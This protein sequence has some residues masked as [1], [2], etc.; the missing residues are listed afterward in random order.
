MLRL[1]RSNL[2]WSVPV[3][4]IAS[5]VGFLIGGLLTT[6]TGNNYFAVIFDGGGT[7]GHEQ[8]VFYIVA[9]MSTGLGALIGLCASQLSWFIV[10]RN[11]Q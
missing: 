5:L 10:H 11:K 6:L 2:L 1:L 8:E 9:A 4:L 7:T 3:T